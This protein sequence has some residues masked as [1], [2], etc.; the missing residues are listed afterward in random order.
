MKKILK[1]E[2]GV[3]QGGATGEVLTKLSNADNDVGWGNGG[4]SNGNVPFSFGQL[5]TPDYSTKYV[6]A[7]AIWFQNYL[8]YKTAL[9]SFIPGNTI[10]GS[11]V[12]VGHD[13]NTGSQIPITSPALHDVSI[14][15]DGLSLYDIQISIFNT[16][17]YVGNSLSIT[18]DQYDSNL[19]LINTY[20]CNI[21]ESYGN[22]FNL[23]SSVL[24]T[25]AFFVKDEHLVI[26]GV[27]YRIASNGNDYA[28]DLTIS[29]ASLINPIQT[30]LLLF[31]YIGSVY[32]QNF[33]SAQPL[34]GNVYM[35]DGGTGVTPGPTGQVFKF[36]Y[37]VINIK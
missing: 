5:T 10:S 15:E 36:T 11:T 24:G 27:R 22:A 14:S 28:I 26:P 3:P 30:N 17:P 9:A 23:N 12:L 31:S 4:G 2:G 6:N 18:L 32:G 21:V 25:I 19:T 35:A 8:I 13:A 34:S 29:G 37:L 16:N 20:T 1:E 33:C 7:N